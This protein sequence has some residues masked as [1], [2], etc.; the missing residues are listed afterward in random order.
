MLPFKEKGSSAA[1]W[2]A[3]TGS[4]KFDT[5]GKFE[6]VVYEIDLNR[7]CLLHELFVDQVGK[8]VNIENVIGIFRL[9]QSHCKRGTAST[10]IV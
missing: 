9:I 5:A 2:A 4:I 3:I 7:L 1:A 10:A 6:T 8:T